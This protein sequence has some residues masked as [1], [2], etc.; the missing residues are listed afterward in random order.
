MV[1]RTLP[2]AL[3]DDVGLP[4]DIDDDRLDTPAVLVDLDVVDANIERYQAFANRQGLALRPHSKT[5]KSVTVAE[6]QLAAG[7]VGI[8]VSGASEALAMT[9]GGVRDVLVAYPLV[10]PRKLERVAPLVRRAAGD[11]ITVSL[12]A[13]SSEVVQGYR[14][15]AR[16]TGRTIPVLVEVDTG[17]NRVGADPA[18]AVKLAEEV[19][20]SQGLEFRG[21]MT[22]AGHSHDASDELGI[23]AVGRQEAMVMGGVREDLEAAGLDVQV[24]SAGSSITSAYLTAADGITEI[25]PGT[26]VYNDLRTLGRHACTPDALA[27]TV[28]ATVVSTSGRRVTIDAGSKTLTPT[29][30]A[31]YGHGHVR[32]RP[33]VVF[34][35]L[36]EEHGV[37]DARD[38]LPM[39]S[40][41]DKVQVLPVHVCVW[42]DL[43]AEVYGVRGGRVV[44]RIAVDAMRHSL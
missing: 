8:T 15:L 44:E 36:S 43:Q 32:H 19:A 25:R 4:I 27:A 26:Y 3:Y 20:R 18:A 11:G 22:H 39:P 23:E 37:M 38:D 41:G 5:H 35:R 33:G 9:A 40:V 29:K 17:M 34:T 30:D 31:A 16:S 7:A 14:E 21:V 12:V 6:R 13:D 2:V 28:L 1:R 10:G 42:M 24:V